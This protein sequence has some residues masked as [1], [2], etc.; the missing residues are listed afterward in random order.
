MH[1]VPSLHIGK[2]PRRWH[3]SVDLGLAHSTGGVCQKGEQAKHQAFT[4]ESRD[5]SAAFQ[6]AKT[7]SKRSEFLHEKPMAF[8]NEA[9]FDGWSRATNK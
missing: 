3:P 5:G 8:N 1:H 2:L 4:R 9:T 7:I 6:A